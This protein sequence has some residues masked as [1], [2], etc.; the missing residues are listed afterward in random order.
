[1]ARQTKRAGAL[2]IKLIKRIEAGSNHD[3]V[4]EFDCMG[5]VEE[6]TEPALLLP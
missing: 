2:P 4:I 5:E 6:I 1:M 3:L